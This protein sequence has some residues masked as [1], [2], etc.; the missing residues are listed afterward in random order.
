[1]KRFYRHAAAVAEAGGWRVALDGRPVKTQGG[2]PLLL[3]TARLAELLAAEWD[4][5]GETIDPRGFPLRD[6]ADYA[7]DIVAADPGAAARA[8]LRYAETDTLCYRADPDEPLWKRQ[9][10]LWEPLVAAC[11][12]REGVRLQRVSG[13]MPKSPPPATL[14]TLGKRLATLDPFTLAALT[15]LAGLAASL[16]IALAALERQVDGEALW[17]AANLEEDWQAEL[18]GRD[19]EAEARRARRRADF[20]A[21]LSFARAL[22]PS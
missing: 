6:L 16:V 7:L 12:A 18:W 8:L 9:Q 3:P 21:T 4:A 15:S 2:N 22:Q 13:V 17:S 11:E 19:A 5:Q 10:E 1:M 14:A 20:M